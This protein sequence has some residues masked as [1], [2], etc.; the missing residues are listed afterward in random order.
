VS[1]DTAVIMESVRYDGVLMN[2]Y[3][4]T[5]LIKT[6][7]GGLYEKKGNIITSAEIGTEGDTLNNTL[8]K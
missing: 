6:S 1:T 7:D 5:I 4:S 2:I 8:N 3:Y